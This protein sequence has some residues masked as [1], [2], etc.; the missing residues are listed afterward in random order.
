LDTATVSVRSAK[1]HARVSTRLHELEGVDGRSAAGKRSRAS[2]S[3]ANVS[4]SKSPACASAA[5]ALSSVAAASSRASI[6][7]ANAARAASVVSMSI[8][9]HPP[10]CLQ[11]APSPPARE[12]DVPAAVLAATR[13]AAPQAGRGTFKN[14]RRR[15]WEPNR[16]G[17]GGDLPDALRK[18]KG[19][20]RIM[21][22]VAAETAPPA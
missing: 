5:R 11:L 17:L 18:E 22:A 14:S 10:L 3:R 21:P 8:I 7:S 6:A 9:A 4:A 19:D 15:G 13:A 20:G 16:T 12:G 2:S 1:A